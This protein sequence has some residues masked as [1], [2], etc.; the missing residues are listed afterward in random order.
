MVYCIFSLGKIDKKI[1]WPFLF[2]IMQVALTLIN[3]LFPLDKVNQVI[4][5][6][7]VSI[8]NMLVLIIP[9][10]FKTKDK[11][12]KKDEICTKNNIKY[13]AIHW[14]ISA[15][16]CLSVALASLGGNTVVISIHSSLL[17][18]REVVEII[19]LP[20]KKIN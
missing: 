18:T 8:G 9:F 3:K 2:A 6:F 17:V 4:D 5:S 14:A 12:I 15:V 20:V 11:I 19:I 13:Q 10:V 1:I 16:F 7:S